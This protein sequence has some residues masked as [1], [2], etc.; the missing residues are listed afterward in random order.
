MK[1]IDVE[2]LNHASVLI[3]VGNRSVLTDP[4][5]WGA[6][7][8]NGWSLLYE[9]EPGHVESTLDRTDAIWI[10]HE[11]P[12]HFSVSFFKKYSAKINALEI[13]IIFQKTSDQRVAG[14]LRNLGLNVIEIEN[15]SSYQMFD[16]V[17]IK[18]IQVG[19]YDSALLI[20]TNDFTILNLNDCE[21]SSKDSAEALFGDLTV[22]ILLTQ[23]SYA[24]WKG[25]KENI[26]WR[27]VAAE[28]KLENIKFQDGFFRPNHIIPFASFIRFSREENFYLN[29]CANSP[30]DVYGLEGLHG[31]VCIL[32]P[33]AKLS[34]ATKD[35]IEKNCDF[36]EKLV[37]KKTVDSQFQAL[38]SV[39]FSDLESAFKRR[40]SRVFSFNS[41]FLMKMFYALGIAFRPMSIFLI[42]LKINIRFDW[43]SN[44]LFFC[45]DS[46]EVF[47]RSG[48][49]LFLLD[50]DFGFDTL[51]VNGCFELSEPKFFGRFVKTF[52]IGSYNAAGIAFSPRVI[53]RLEKFIHGLRTLKRVRDSLETRF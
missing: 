22:D 37:S 11:H 19:L 33:G 6:A 9:N 45:Q 25:G 13:P 16:D 26:K 3:T 31:E 24:A 39:P 7:F 34:S 42:D 51:T 53:F 28:K 41:A 44:S 50:H 49:F 5:F 14:F 38:R 27:R 1:N 36:W 12:D 4:W 32:A 15:Q 23:F 10:S 2:L 8:N 47:L 40:Q 52:G 48:D 18:V 46:P 17:F 20:E 35:S 43:F 30:V 29:D 21:V